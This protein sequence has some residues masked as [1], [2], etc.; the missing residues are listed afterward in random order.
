MGADGSMRLRFF[1]SSGRP[2][3]VCFMV[4]VPRP[5]RQC[6]RRGRWIWMSRPIRDHPKR[7]P[8]SSFR[9]RSNGDFVAWELSRISTRGSSFLHPSLVRFGLGAAGGWSGVAG[10]IPLS[11]TF[12]IL[13]RGRL[14]HRFLSLQNPSDGGK[15]RMNVTVVPFARCIIEQIL[16]PYLPTRSPLRLMPPRQN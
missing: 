11:Y 10:L 2:Y 13:S 12:V 14:L 3:S 6:R 8:I 9:Q 5:V 7:C 4:G 15:P 16:R 1:S